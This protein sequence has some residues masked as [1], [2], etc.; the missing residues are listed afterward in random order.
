ME[1]D[2]KAMFDYLIYDIKMN[3]QKWILTQYSSHNID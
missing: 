2:I 1:S 3:E